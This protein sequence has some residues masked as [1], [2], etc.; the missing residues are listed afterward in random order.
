M[1]FAGNYRLIFGISALKCKIYNASLIYGNVDACHYFNYRNNRPRVALSPI[2]WR[3]LRVLDKGWLVVKL[4][5]HGLIS[6]PPRRV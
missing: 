3:A 5:R 1:D 4:L 6:S 2:Y